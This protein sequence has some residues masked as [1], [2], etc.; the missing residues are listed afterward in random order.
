MSIAEAF[1][2]GVGDHMGGVMMNEGQGDSVLVGRIIVDGAL[3]EWYVFARRR[4]HTSLRR[5]WSSDVC[6]SD[7]PATPT[8]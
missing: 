7:H 5:G 6:S 4:R 2:K 3:G 8:E 1:L